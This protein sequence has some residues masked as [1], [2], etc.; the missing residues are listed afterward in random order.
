MSYV[1][2]FLGGLAVGLPVGAV[3]WYRFGTKL[4]ADKIKSAI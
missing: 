2:T 1:I 3:L 4:A